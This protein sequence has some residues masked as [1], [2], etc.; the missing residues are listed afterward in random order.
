MEMIAFIASVILLVGSQ[1][2][3]DTPTVRTVDFDPASCH[4]VVIDS[5]SGLRNPTFLANVP[6]DA[7]HTVLTIEENDRDGASVVMLQPDVQGHFAVV[8]RRQ[9]PDHGPCHI[10]VSPDRSYAVTANY[11]GNSVCIVPFDCS[12][13]SFGEPDTLAFFGRGP[14]PSRQTKP[15]A[16][17]TC[18]T[19]DGRMMWVND[20]GMDVI[21]TYVLGNDGRPVAESR[22]DVAVTPGSGPR[23]TVFGPD[24]RHAYLITEIGGTIITLHY[25]PET[26]TVEPVAETHIDYAFGEGSSQIAISADGRHLYGSNRLKGDGIVALNVSDGGET[27]SPLDFV[28]TGIHPR[29]FAIVGNHLIV[30]ARDS[31]RLDIFSIAP[32]GT[33]SPCSTLSVPRPMMILPI[34]N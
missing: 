29:H 18:F 30:G 20:L 9:I 6:G 24:G 32:D 13:R 2:N 28:E 23:H 33:L 1:G 8:A 14:H 4:A 12:Q 21:H 11:G 3:A 19:P 27:L 25:H 10:A 34:Q 7:N 22:R 31:D 15:H 17:F 5:I 26:Q 16:H